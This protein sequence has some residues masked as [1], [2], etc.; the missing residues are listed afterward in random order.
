MTALT[1]APAPAGPLTTALAEARAAAA[2]A[3]PVQGPTSKSP[4]A[5]KAAAEKAVELFQRI[6]KLADAASPPPPS[7]L[8][9]AA[10]AEDPVKIQEQVICG[11]ADLYARIGQSAELRQLLVVFRPFFATLPKARTAKI[12]R[13]IIDLVARIK[14][15]E[16][17]QVNCFFNLWKRPGGPRRKLTRP[18]F[19][20]AV[21]G[22]KLCWVGPRFC[23]VSVAFGRL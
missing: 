1:L 2:A 18:K 5:D 7:V 20:L 9:G 11:L 16:E 13:T 22:Q 3:A 21:A 17:Q 12:V 23:P 10:P 8:P 6:F 4:A 14:G 19:S 15:T